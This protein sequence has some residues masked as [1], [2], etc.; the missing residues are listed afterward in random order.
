MTKVIVASFKE[1]KKAI[2]ALHKLKELDSFGD[3]ALY[4]SV[5][6]RKQQDNDYEI[7]KADSSEGWRVLT[8]MAVGGLLGAL[9]GP[10]GLIIGLYT[11][12]AIGAISDASHYNF[13]EDFVAGVENKMATGTVSIIAEID[14]ESSVFIDDYFK[15]F[16]AVI[17]RS[18]VDFDYDTYLGEEIDVIDDEIT[19]ERVS[20]KKSIGDEKTKI[21]KKIAVLK[22]KRKLKVAEFDAAAKK[23]AA[24]IKDKA[25]TGAAE[26]RDGAK[27]VGKDIT[28]AAHE[29]KANRIKK[30]IARHEARLSKLHKELEVLA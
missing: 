12:T 18:D 14:E 4:E 9:G 28:D 17:T 8:G 7:L 25:Q 22:E 10:I 11:G 6:V 26:I 20:L 19:E 27:G 2:G 23:M 29:A 21:E 16:D 30:R 24:T 1:E 13:A 5:L 3:I 15:P